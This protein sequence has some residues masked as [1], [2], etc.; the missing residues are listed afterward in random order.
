MAA[1]TAPT[2]L[3]L[4]PSSTTTIS[5]RNGWACKNVCSLASVGGSRSSSLYAG[6]MTERSTKVTSS[7]I[8]VAPTWEDKPA[9]RGVRPREEHDCRADRFRD[10]HGRAELHRDQMHRERHQQSGCHGNTAE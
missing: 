8:G 3:S 1:C 9:L 2:V 4:E 5:Y 10:Q 6:T 7:D